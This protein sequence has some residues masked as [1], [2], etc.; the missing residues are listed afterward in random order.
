MYRKV[1]ADQPTLLLDE[2]DTMFGTRASERT[3]G[4]R[5]LLNAG[6]RRGTTVPRMVGE[7]RKMQVHDFSTFCPKVLAGIGHL[8]DT[9]ADR[10][11]VISLQRRAR[12]E[13]VERFRQR[14]AKALTEDVRHA[15][16]DALAAVVEPLSDARPDIPEALG[17]RAA[18]FM[19]ATSGHRRRRRR[20]LARSRAC[21]GCGALR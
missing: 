7:G 15:L 11:I 16:M 3:E 6:N 4:I 10:S 13:P 21:S 14:E 1:E 5:A 8:P 12:N 2:L 17:D 18:E 20:S 9:V 19:G